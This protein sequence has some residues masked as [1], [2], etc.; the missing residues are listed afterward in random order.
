VERDGDV[1]TLGQTNVDEAAGTFED[2]Y[3]AK[4][5]WLSGRCY[6]FVKG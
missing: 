4:G 5:L 1:V 6:A 2:P 3:F